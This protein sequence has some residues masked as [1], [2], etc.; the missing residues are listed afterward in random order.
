MP[1]CSR[2]GPGISGAAVASQS[3][4]SR[5]LLTDFGR[6]CIVGGLILLAATYTTSGPETCLEALLGAS[7]VELQS[8][9]RLCRFLKGSKLQ[10]A[11]LQ[12]LVDAVSIQSGNCLEPTKWQCPYTR[13]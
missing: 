10:F 12:S 3:I 5:F 7:I 11:S 2:K 13:I 9:L 8:F 4:S 6:T 1:R